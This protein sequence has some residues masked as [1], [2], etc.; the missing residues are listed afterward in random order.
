MKKLWRI[1]LLVFM[2]TGLT[3]AA[4]DDTTLPLRFDHYYKLDEI[5]AA[6]KALNTAY[7]ELT[8]FEEVGK[9]DE[10]RSIYAMT[11]NNPKTGPALDKPGIYIDGNIHGNEIQGGDISL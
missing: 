8:V 6:L 3:A 10:G 2:A 7:P 1:G 5:T 9:S 11:V 4:Q